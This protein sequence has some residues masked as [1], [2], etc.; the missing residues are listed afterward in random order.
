MTELERRLLDALKGVLPYAERDIEELSSLLERP[1]DS[2]ELDAAWAALEAAHGLVA[3]NGAT[4]MRMI[5]QLLKSWNATE[6]RWM[7]ALE[8]A[9]PR[10]W[11]GDTRCDRLRN[12]GEPGS[13]LRAAY[14]TNE[15]A[16]AA[17]YAAGGFAAY[18]GLEDKL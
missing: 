16:E 17:F 6:E 10:E 1:A 12:A 11:A 5:E 3:L 7:R 8:T 2:D 4:A 15:A 13:P 18:F 9:Y 14:D